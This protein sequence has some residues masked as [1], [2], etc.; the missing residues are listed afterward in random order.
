MHFF[1]LLDICQKNLK[2]ECVS[3]DK[4]KKDL[5]DDEI[6]DKLFA[7]KE[8][9]RLDLDVQN[10]ENHCFSVNIKRFKYTKFLTSHSRSHFQSII[11]F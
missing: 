6:N 1:K 9:L 4:L 11:K 7:A 10:F 5:E 2:N 8:K 3:G